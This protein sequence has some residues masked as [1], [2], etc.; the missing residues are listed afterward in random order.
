MATQTTLNR[1]EGCH[2]RCHACLRRAGTWAHQST[3]PSPATANRQMA[4]VAPACCETSQTCVYKSV[5]LVRTVGDGVHHE[6]KST[7]AE[8]REKVRESTQ[9]R[10]GYSAMCGLH[11]TNRREQRMDGFSEGSPNIVFHH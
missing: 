4:P 5:N 6:G 3:A 11:S 9:R 2:P 8:W 10:G 1:A 7:N